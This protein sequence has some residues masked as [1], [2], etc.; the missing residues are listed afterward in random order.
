[1]NETPCT[2]NTLDDYLA[3]QRLCAAE[4][5]KQLAFLAEYTTPDDDWNST[6]EYS[7]WEIAAVIRAT[8]RYVQNR[9]ALA[10]TLATF[11]PRPGRRC[12]QG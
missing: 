2:L 9:I 4:T 7:I 6:G 8:P 11:C 3:S 1:V 12:G 5:E 10:H